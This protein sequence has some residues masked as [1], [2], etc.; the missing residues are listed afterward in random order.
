MKPAILAALLLFASCP[1]LRAAETLLVDQGAPDWQDEQI[2]RWGPS[3]HH[4]QP[5]AAISL[6]EI[7]E[8]GLLLRISFSTFRQRTCRA[9]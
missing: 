8:G 5:K 3:P 4:I 9:K 2:K 7:R 6:N 1:S